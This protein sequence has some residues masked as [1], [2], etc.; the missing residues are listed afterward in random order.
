MKDRCSSFAALSC[1]ILSHPTQ[2]TYS[3]ATFR[4]NILQTPVKSEWVNY[5]PGDT[6]FCK[7]SKHI[8]RIW[9]S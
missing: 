7:L 9:N 5:T 6:E 8:Y 1:K 4:Y 3:S 2:Q